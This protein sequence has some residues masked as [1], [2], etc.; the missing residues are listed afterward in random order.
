MLIVLNTV[1]FIY[2]KK[3]INSWKRKKEFVNYRY[4]LTDRLRT[5]I[6]VYNLSLL[7]TKKF[8]KVQGKVWSRSRSKVMALAPFS[9][10][11]ADSATPV[12]LQL[13]LW[14]P[15][16]NLL[17][18]EQAIFVGVLVLLC[19]N[20]FFLGG[21]LCRATLLRHFS[22]CFL[23]EPQKYPCPP[24]QVKYRYREQNRHD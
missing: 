2:D 17:S 4:T 10:P 8:F 15:V 12:T 7:V 11:S 23:H 14:I 24:T 19:P 16:G 20:F 5:E 3:P 18:K 9:S 22:F 6:F 21:P 1:N 13:I